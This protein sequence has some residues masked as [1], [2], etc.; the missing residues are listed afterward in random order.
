[1]RTSVFAAIF[2]LAIGVVPS[3]T[4]IPNEEPDS[5]SNPTKKHQGKGRRKE[6]PL[7]RATTKSLQDDLDKDDNWVLYD[8]IDD[9]G[10]R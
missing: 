6:I 9:K 7:R 3:F 8:H 5:E 1:M 10:L 4:K 2:F